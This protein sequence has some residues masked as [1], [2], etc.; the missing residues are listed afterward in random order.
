MGTLCA[1]MVTQPLPSPIFSQGVHSV[2]QHAV[3]AVIEGQSSRLGVC[4]ELVFKLSFEA[5]Q[6][7]PEEWNQL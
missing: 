7:K 2:C 1:I 5:M 6:G 4:W 3:I